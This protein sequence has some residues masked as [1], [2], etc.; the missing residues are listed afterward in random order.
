[1]PTDASPSALTD[2]SNPSIR[3]SSFSLRSRRILL[4]AG[5]CRCISR[6]SSSAVPAVTQG[7]PQAR[8]MLWSR[9]DKNRTGVAVTSPRTM[10]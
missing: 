10:K 7:T 9:V 8:P 3:T 6:A 2:S 5:S 1:M 4:A